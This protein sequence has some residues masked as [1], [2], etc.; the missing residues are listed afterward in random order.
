MTTIRD[1]N[2]RAVGI[3]WFREEDYPAAQTLFESTNYL[4]PWEEWLQ[5]AQELEQR[6]KGEGYIV[7]RVYIDLDTFPDWC[8]QNGKR[9]DAQARVDFA[10]ETVAKKYGRNQS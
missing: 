6:F 3:A 9:I 7:E 10:A 1:Y 8:A 2:A 5:R 4:P